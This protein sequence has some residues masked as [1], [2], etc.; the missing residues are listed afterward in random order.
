MHFTVI[1]ICFRFGS[2][3]LVD[4]YSEF[5]NYFK[6][7]PAQPAAVFGVWVVM[8]WVTDSLKVMDFTGVLGCVEKGITPKGNTP[9]WLLDAILFRG[10]G[11]AV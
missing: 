11:S 3:A 9:R 1:H 5:S 8:K 4:A 7:L 10:T 6:N 2:R